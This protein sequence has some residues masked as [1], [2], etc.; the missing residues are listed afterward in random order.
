MSIQLLE[1]QNGIV[2]LPILNDVV[3]SHLT[4]D[5]GKDGYDT[6]QAPEGDHFAP[7]FIPF[8][9]AGDGERFFLCLATRPDLSDGK[10]YDVQ[11]RYLDVHWLKGDTTYYWQVS[12]ETEQSEI[13]SFTTADTPRTIYI[14][15]VANTR[16]LGGR[17]TDDG[18]R[19]R[20]GLLYRG[21]QLDTATPVGITYCLRELG[22]RCE[23]DLRAPGEGGAG[24]ES[25][26][27]PDVRYLNIP[28]TH[29]S[30]CYRPEHRNNMQ[31]IFLTFADPDNYPIFFHCFI[32]R[33]RTGTV[34]FML[35]ALLGVS[36]EDLAK[37]YDLTQLSEMYRYEV[38]P[39]AVLHRDCFDPLACRLRDY[40]GASLKENAERYM[41]DLG[42]TDEDVASIR[43]I[44]LED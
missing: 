43:A 22:I 41:R 6:Y 30:D 38:T 25:L 37:D 2:D 9:W 32:G 14:E 29:Y 31:R 16:D 7:L 36:L 28:G 24:V 20:E 5:L 12:S 21:P 1:P 35:G 26:L 3:L 34:A 27:G 44:L 17:Y 19:V 11:G 40:G 13:F 4:N 10:I 42:L 33:D 23:L 15:G 8:R 39:L 18:K